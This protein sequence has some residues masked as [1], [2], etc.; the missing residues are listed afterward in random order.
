MEHN[1]RTKDIEVS[2]EEEAELYH[3]TGCWFYLRQKELV[4]QQ[5]HIILFFEYALLLMSPGR[6]AILPS[7][8]LRT[9]KVRNLIPDLE[10]A[11]QSAELLK[12]LADQ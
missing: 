12:A 5:L 4:H 10:T 7:S 9:K 3:W 6:P 8:A 11:V 1:I 2:E